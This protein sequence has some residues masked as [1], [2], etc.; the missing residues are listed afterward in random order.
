MKK[1][2][3]LRKAK[4][5]KKPNF[6]RSDWQKLGD[7]RWRAPRGMH[8]KLRRKFRGKVKQPSIGFSS[9]KLVKGL[10]RQ[11]LREIIISNLKDLQ[12]ITKEN[13][14]IISSKVGVKKKLE[15]IKKI[16]E[17]KLSI[18]NLKNPEK[19]IKDVEEKTKKK[20]AEK[21]SKEEKKKKEK[22]KI[23]KKAKEKEEVPK[24]EKEKQVK[25]EKRKVLE[26]KQ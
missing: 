1:L 25:E 17:L 19:F 26:K 13:A 11:G 8:S 3:E 24:E 9:P 15:L 2:L 4:K 20:K 6:Y 14:I 5:A 22:E 18:S 12:K 7:K 21:K 10:N 23:E 16:L